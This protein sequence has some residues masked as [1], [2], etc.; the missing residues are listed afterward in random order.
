MNLCT[1][2]RTKGTHT[3]IV[4]DERT[5]PLCEVMAELE[6]ITKG[7]EQDEDDW[8]K[9]RATLQKQIDTYEGRKW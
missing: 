9:E 2:H 7:W 1:G 5:C 4:H 6:D 8:N 3:E